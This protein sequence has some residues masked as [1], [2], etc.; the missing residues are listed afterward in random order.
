LASRT[1]DAIGKRSD[2]AR[3]AIRHLVY[4]LVHPVLGAVARNRWLIRRL[5]GVRVPRDTVV[6]FDATT[7]L[8]RHVLPLAVR[9]ADRVAL[10]VGIGQGAL[11]A[12]ALRR[13][14]HL[15]VHGLDCS[16]GRVSSSQ[17]VAE[18]NGID[19]CFFR[20][21]LFSQVAPGRLY[22]LIFCNPPYVPTREGRQLRLT[23][24][25]RADSD[26]VWDGGDDGTRVLQTFLERAAD[27]LQPGGRVLFGV[28]PIFIPPARV[29][30]MVTDC[31]WTIVQRWRRRWIGSVA[32]L[33][34]SD[35][36]A[37][38]SSVQQAS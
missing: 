3:M 19:A 11:L 5:F 26:R 27:Y 36:N 38:R 10:E 29:E 28:Q 34:T 30:Q 17:R 35:T 25:M 33:L 32:Y 12:L 22:D 37:A 31:G 2:E 23:R 18:Y 13:T 7:L 9:P 24:R 4:E 14:T 21:D 20:S 6:H 1:I 8:L 15:E 16:A